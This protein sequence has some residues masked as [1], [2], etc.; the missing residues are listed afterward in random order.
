MKTTLKNVSKGLLAAAF[1]LALVFIGSAF[2]PDNGAK[3]AMYTFYY[4][5]PDYSVAEVTDES[6]WRHDADN[7]ICSGDNQQACTIQVS[8]AYVDSPLAAPK[9]LKSSLNLTAAT[10]AP[11]IAFINGAADGSLQIYNEVRP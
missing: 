11:N 7:N 8:D 5:G 9:T 6:N 1:G 10:S 2:K 4:D 3:R